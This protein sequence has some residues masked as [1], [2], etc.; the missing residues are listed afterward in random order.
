MWVLGIEPRSCTRTVSALIHRS[1]SPHQQG[2]ANLSYRVR[3][4]A[5][6]TKPTKQKSQ[7]LKIHK[8]KMEDSRS[9]LFS[10]IYP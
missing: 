3:D 5:L 6:K 8:N 10:G 4:L 2:E 7:T 9:V 1:I